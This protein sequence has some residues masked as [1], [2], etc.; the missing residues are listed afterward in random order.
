MVSRRDVIGGGVSSVA[1]ASV[2]AGLTATA[3][4][5]SKRPGWFAQQRLPIGLQLYTVG[6]AARA[7]IDATLGKV[8]R[9]G[10]KAI[11]LAGY[12]GQTVAALL[13]AKNKHGV[14][15][16]SIHVGATARPGEPGLDGDIPRLAAELHS[17]GITD[18]AMPMFAFPVR[19][20]APKD[21]EGF[22][23]YLQRVAAGLTREDWLATAEL[24]NDRGAKLRREGLRFSYHNHN[25][26][27]APVAGTTGLDILLSNTS[28]VDVAFEMDVGWV[29]AAGADPVTLLQKH[30][31]R[32]QLMHVKDIR[33]TTKPNFALSQ[34]PTE[35][36][37]G[38]LE[39]ARILPAAFKA[40]VRKFYVEQE[41]PFTMD[42]FDAI[43]KSFAYLSALDVTQRKA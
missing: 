10:Y 32:F 40:G 18:V 16:T 25:P 36:G 6:D 9:V 34:D 17:L 38:R 12:H 13:A 5:A 41:P 21:G 22:L 27:L 14:K 28:A 23:V 35:V 33:A 42:R 24:L 29:A 20:G 7:D 15:F 31:R 1:L 2:G 8:A 30:G 43:A 4:A 11:E 37:S 39:W 19:F 26:E 3:W